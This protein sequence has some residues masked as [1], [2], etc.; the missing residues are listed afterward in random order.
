[1][2]LGVSGLALA[3]HPGLALAQ[4]VSAAPAQSDDQPATQGNEDPVNE[5]PG[6]N[7]TN[8][9]QEIVVTAKRGP[10]TVAHALDCALA[11][12]EGLCEAALPTVIGPERDDWARALV[13]DDPRM[14]PLK[15]SIL[16]RPAGMESERSVP[17]CA[18]VCFRTLSMR[19]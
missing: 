15:L 16:Q 10:R 12:V 3:A 1:M 8:T 11:V 18:N 4:D 13:F 19:L 14:R 6:E 7:P 9:E 2:V 17:T 5:E